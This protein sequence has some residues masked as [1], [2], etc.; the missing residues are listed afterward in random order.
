MRNLVT[1]K[2]IA[3][4]LDVTVMSVS[5]ALSGKE[6]V[7]EDLRA[8]ILAKADEL[9]YKKTPA[10]TDDQNSRNI[11]IL[12]AERSLNANVSFMSL[13]QPLITSLSQLNYYGI[14]E[15]ISDESEHLL[16]LPKI[17]KENKVKA[18]IV[19][20]QMN[21][22]YIDVLKKTEKPFLFLGHL[23]DNETAGAI[24]TDNLYAG[25]T[26]ANYLL[27]Q[28]CKSIG[29]VG[30]YQF[31]EMV[32]DRFLGI[33]KALLHRGLELHKELIIP[34]V[35]DYGEEISLFLPDEMPDS[36]IC[37]DCRTAYKL[38][39]NLE[40]LEYNVPKDISVA[41]FDDGIFA[42]IGIP[43]LTTYSVN[44]ETMAQLAAESIALKLENPSYH[45]G[46]KVVHGSVIIRDSVRK[47]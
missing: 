41:A 4:E 13:Q 15:I 42:D 10:Q 30:N 45:I 32:M 37:N 21:R 20:G 19:L 18:F 12:V 5:K 17:L 1:M 40:G 35:N 23:Y 22:D 33:A 28:G 6:G 24:L 31:A 38:I 11:G 9:G 43:K 3:D 36:F 16:L 14:T 8:K 2:D 47:L 39:H 34:D 46:K 29:F 44:Y 26:L 25:Y 7:S 27:D